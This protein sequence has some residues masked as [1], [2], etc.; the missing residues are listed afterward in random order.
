MIKSVLTSISLYFLS[1]FRAPVAITKK[2]N[3]IQRNFLWRAKVGEKKVAWVK[4][5]DC[6]TLKENG[7]LGI[8]NIENFNKALLGKWVWRG[9][10]EKSKF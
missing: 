4:W 10:T 3:S 2:I 5:S 1:M 7:G 8:K 6:C 9:L